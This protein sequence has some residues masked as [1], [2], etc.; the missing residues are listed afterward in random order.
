MDRQKYYS[1]NEILFSNAK[2]QLTYAV[3]REPQKHYAK[4][5]KSDTKGHI[6]Y[7]S[8]YMKC[9]EKVNLT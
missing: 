4:Q 5:K 7:D 9:S 2:E 1:Y 3:R 6:S 8:I